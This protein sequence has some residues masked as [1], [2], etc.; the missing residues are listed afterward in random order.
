[1]GKDFNA[2]LERYGSDAAFRERL[3]TN[4]DEAISEYEL[5]AEEKEEIR[6]HIEHVA[7]KI[8]GHASR[9]FNDIL[10]KYVK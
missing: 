6:R 8:E 9:V 2:Y 3:K 1:M 7:P 5:T 4:F 10:D